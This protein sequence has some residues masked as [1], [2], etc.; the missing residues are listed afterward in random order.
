MERRQAD[1]CDFFFTKRHLMT[2]SDGRRT[3]RICRRHGCC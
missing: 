1:V 3:R 2:K